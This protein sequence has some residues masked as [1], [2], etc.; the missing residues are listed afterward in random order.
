MVLCI[1]LNFLEK[2]SVKKSQQLIV[3]EHL[4]LPRWRGCKAKKTKLI[5]FI[6]YPDANNFKVFPCFKPKSSGSKQ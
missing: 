3:N 1:K 5:K 2:K 4:H 6:T